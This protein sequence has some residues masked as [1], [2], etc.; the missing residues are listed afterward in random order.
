MNDRHKFVA[1]CTKHRVP[2]SFIG[3]LIGVNKA[4]AFQIHKENGE[5][6]KRCF[7]CR[8]ELIGK[9]NNQKVELCKT[10]SEGQEK[11]IKLTREKISKQS[12]QNVVEESFR[13]NI[14]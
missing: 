9:A 1:L 7:I 12:K 6:I 5:E 4:R 11:A 13:N 2:F 8:K 3:K 14:K 10:C